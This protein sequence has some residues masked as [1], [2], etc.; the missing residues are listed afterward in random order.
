MKVASPLKARSAM[1]PIS[2]QA[3][4]QTSENGR[5]IA[6]QCRRRTDSLWTTDS[7]LP[8]P[9][10]QASPYRATS[11]SVFYSPPPPTMK[12]AIG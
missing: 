6:S 12:P 8:Q 1:G 2:D 4:F 9:T 5:P 3:S 11:R 10:L 7:G